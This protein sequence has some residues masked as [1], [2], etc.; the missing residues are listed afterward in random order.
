MPVRVTL[1]NTG[2]DLAGKVEVTVVDVMNNQ[3]H[4]TQEVSLPAVSRKEVTILVFIPASGT[5]TTISFVTKEGT[6]RETRQNLTC[7]ATGGSLVGVW[8]STPSVYNLF[9]TLNLAGG[10][11]TVAQL[12]PESFS[13]HPEALD[14]LSML[15]IS[16]VD[17]GALSESQRQALVSWV[18][19]GGRLTVIGGPGWQK[20]VAGLADLLPLS[21]EKTLTLPDLTGLQFYNP[22]SAL[23]PANTVVTTGTLQ[24]SALILATQDNTPLIVRHKIG[25]GDV[26]FLAADPALAPLRNWDGMEALYQTIYSAALDQPSWV[27]G[28]SSMSD[29]S[30]AISNIPGLGLPSIFLICGFLGLY[31]LAL[32]PL[33]YLV[34]RQLKRRELAWLTIPALVVVFSLAA[35]FLGLFT[36]GTSAIVNHLAIVQVWPEREEASVHGL[37]G[38]FSPNRSTY[39]LEVKGNFLAYPLS[40]G[41]IG[42]LSSIQILQKD[43]GAIAENL[44]IDAGGLGGIAVTGHVPAPDFASNLTMEIAN[45]TIHVQ[46]QV[47]NNSP[48]T[49][50][51]AMIIGPGQVQKIGDFEPGA[52]ETVNLQ[53][54]FTSNATPNFSSSLTPSYYYDSTLTDVFGINYVDNSTDPDVARRFY[55]LQAALGYSGTRG[56]GVYLLGWTDSSP[57]D[58]E[59]GGKGFTGEHT[60]IYIVALNP[61]LQT[62]NSNILVMPPALF[63]WN[64]LDNTSYTDATPYGAYVY[65]GIYTFRF[66]LNQAIPYDKVSSLTYH[67]TSYGTTGQTDLDISL[68]DFTENQWAPIPVDTWGDHPIS[69]PERYVGTGG[70]IRVQI[71]NP[72][73]YSVSIERSDF[74][75]VVEQ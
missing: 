23:P 72:F 63:S 15:V 46:G 38:V 24:P 18:E 59:L 6:V 70:E 21:P 33:N 44:R 17:T 10:K 25:F 54:L 65:E 39:N 29:A 11:T 45:S 68:W 35:F 55:L 47:T 34:L 60:S 3:W 32:G 43:D 57:L 41:Q 58:V 50:K 4:Y 71:E 48:L 42:G 27:N 31:I 64:V 66:Q 7:L 16:D 49:L 61:T 5:S 1:E 14:M 28:F 37:I 36:R 12:E 22:A 52:Q 69:D 51:E 20:T 53:F 75:L 56:G 30:L 40:D 2:P 19:N 13:S 67:L 9:T 26:F 74:T 62:G 73:Q 8:A